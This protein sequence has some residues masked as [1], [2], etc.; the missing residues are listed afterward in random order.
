MLIFLGIAIYIRQTGVQVHGI[1]METTEENLG[2][3]EVGANWGLVM[4]KLL[5]R[6]E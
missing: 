5:E 3:A 2:C 6:F 1:K 4:P